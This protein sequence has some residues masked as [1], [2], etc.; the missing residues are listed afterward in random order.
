MS[1]IDNKSMNTYVYSYRLGEGID[2][3]GNSKGSPDPIAQVAD[4]YN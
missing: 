3:W 4:G 2:R 1:L